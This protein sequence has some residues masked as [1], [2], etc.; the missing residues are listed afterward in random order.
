MLSVSGIVFL[1]MVG[2]LFVVQPFYTN[3][4]LFAEH[5]TEAAAMSCFWA[6]GPPSTYIRGL[7]VHCLFMNWCNVHAYTSDAAS[8]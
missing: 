7:L 8:T 5:E 6:V 4:E 2:G 3:P 1:T